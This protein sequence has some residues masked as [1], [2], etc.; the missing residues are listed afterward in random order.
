[1]CCLCCSEWS[2]SIISR[3][4]GGSF[5]LGHS[6]RRWS[7]TY[8]RTDTI[9]WSHLTQRGV[10]DV[11]VCVHRGLHH[12]LAC[13]EGGRAAGRGGRGL[14]EWAAGGAEGAAG[15][16]VWPTA[17]GQRLETHTGVGRL[18]ICHRRLIKMPIVKW[19][20][21]TALFLR[22][23]FTQQHSAELWNAGPCEKGSGKSQEPD[24]PLQRAVHSQLS[25]SVQNPKRSFLWFV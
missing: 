17:A 21:V 23:C 7:A 22:C 1:M 19:R 25:R 9:K 8:I 24:G 18:V 14:P 11:C 13:G 3:G 4:D 2:C 10:I 20:S 15:E 16:S 6:H 5:R 12:V